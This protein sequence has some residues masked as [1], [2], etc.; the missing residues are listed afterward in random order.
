M[1]GLSREQG[2]YHDRHERWPRDAMDPSASRTS[3]VA[4]GRRNRVVRIP[5]RWDQAR[6]RFHGWWRL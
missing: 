6:G 5:R 3:D 1:V 4:G 2:A